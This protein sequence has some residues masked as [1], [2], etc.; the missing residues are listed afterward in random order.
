[1]TTKAEKA[2][3]LFESGYNCSQAVVGAFADDIGMDFDKAVRLASSFGG[4]MGRMQEVCGAVS[5]MF[6][7]AGLLFGYS[8]PEASDAKMEHYKFI[9]ELAE[10]FKQ[11][12]GSIICRELLE[13]GKDRHS[14]ADFVYEAAQII[15]NYM[16]NI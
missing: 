9:R 15:E 6:M 16:N 14:C 13:K 1:M 12:N 3:E 2:R 7:V 5:G 8:S 4:G 11:K 10:E